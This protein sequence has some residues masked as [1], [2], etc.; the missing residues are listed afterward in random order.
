MASKRRSSRKRRP[1]PKPREISG[2]EVK[3]AIAQVWRGYASKGG[4]ARA[5]K[6][7]PERRR[8]IAAMGGA[9]KAEHKQTTTRGKPT[10]TSWRRG[11]V[12]EIDPKA[13][14]AAFRKAFPDM[15]RRKR[16]KEEKA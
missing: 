14:G 2:A 7:S 10:I 3:A 16:T 13:L 9:A 11:D 15:K 12:I 5:A 6:L 8:G 1:R 4:H